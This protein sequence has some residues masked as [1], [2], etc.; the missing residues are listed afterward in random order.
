MPIDVRPQ[1]IV[2]L[3][4]LGMALAFAV[5]DRRSPTSRTLS[6][7]L[8]GVGLSI[9]VGALVALP[10]HARHGLQWWSGI[11]AIP[12]TL[13]FVFA[14]EWIL[15]VR[16]TVPARNL[17][18]R[19]G[20]RQLRVAQGLALLYF[21]LALALPAER[22]VYFQNVEV[23]TRPFG[24]WQFWIFA[25]PLGVSLVLG[26]G[27]VL[28]LLN[29]RPDKAELIRLV[30]FIVGAPIM[31]LGLVVPVDYAPVTTAIGLL[32]F[33]V[34]GVQYHVI[35]GARGQFMS[36][37]LSPQVAELVRER[38]LR[39]ATQEQTLEI[40]V[41]CC[42]LRGF[43]AFSAATESREVIRIL[44]EYYDAVGAAA[45]AVGGTIKDQA[46]DGVLILIGAPIA[47][48]DHAQ[49]ALDLAA[50]IRGEG[51][52]LA[53]RWS[54]AE[55]RL[56]VGVGAASGYVTVGVIGGA[57]RL[58]YTAVGPAVNLASRLCAEA[59]A[60]EVLVDARTC[61]LIADEVR[62]ARLRSGEALRLKGF[63]EP[64]PSFTLGAG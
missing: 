34:G 17:Q 15:R 58:E 21:G 38:G 41:V 32:I 37:F 14:Y 52:A 29:R 19:F 53:A 60:G 36:R 40:S 35:Q 20:D 63:P 27:S 26:I 54:R 33:L 55:R 30:A 64:V 22:S 45:G 62:R 16:R 12:E 13:A 61:E 5:A 10:F 2:A 24:A 4:C 57:S 6:L 43:T 28:L 23:G 1:V 31:A 50:R 46:G 42:D 59:P 56:G 44:R 47:F 18:T 51:G 25:A 11:F 9:G 3:M 8:A 39:S 7:F 49:R 48:P